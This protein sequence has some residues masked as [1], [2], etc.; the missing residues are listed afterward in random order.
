MKFKICYG[1]DKLKTTFFV[2][3]ELN[4]IDHP[5]ARVG[6]DVLNTLG[7]GKSGAGT[8]GASLQNRLM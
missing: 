3:N 2:K 1:V 7:Y 4:K 6:H 8:S 5:Y